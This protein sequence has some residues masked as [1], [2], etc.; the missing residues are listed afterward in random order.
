M[1]QLLIASL[2]FPLSH[3]LM[4]NRMGIAGRHFGWMLLSLVIG[5]SLTAMTHA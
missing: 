4:A 5:L 3:I 2:F 1:T